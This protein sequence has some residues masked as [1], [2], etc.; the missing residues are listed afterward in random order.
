MSANQRNIIGMRAKNASQA[1]SKLNSKLMS[2]RNSQAEY[3]GQRAALIS[4]STEFFEGFCPDISQRR[5]TQKREKQKARQL[6][7][8]QQQPFIHLIDK[9]QPDSKT[10]KLQ[11]NE[12]RLW[13]S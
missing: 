11:I 1:A 5:H 6:P 8:Q 10:K 13:I 12:P 2:Q 9:L 3:G 4:K 7:R